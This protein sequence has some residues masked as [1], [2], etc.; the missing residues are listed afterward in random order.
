MEENPG[1]PENYF[2]IVYSIY[3]FGWTIDLEKSILLVSRYLKKR[4]IFVFLLGSKS[5]PYKVF[6][7]S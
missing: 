2:D 7:Q 6:A 4:G 3:A 1:I 5:L